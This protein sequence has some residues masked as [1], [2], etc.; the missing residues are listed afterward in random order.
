MTTPQATTAINFEIIGNHE[1]RYGNPVPYVRSTQHGQHKPAVRRYEG[2]KQYVVAHFLDAVPPT[3][4][5]AQ[6]VVI[7]GK[8]IVLDSD[9]RARMDI[10][11]QFSGRSHGDPDNVW[12][13]IADAL[14]VNDS[15]LDG[16]F[17]HDEHANYLGASVTVQIS[18]NR[19]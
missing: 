17:T 15:R 18:L 10:Q 11:I 9:E 13:G 8:P 12:K 1:K 16:S 14:F 6:E 3:S 4:R 7:S 2:W 5:Y 19:K